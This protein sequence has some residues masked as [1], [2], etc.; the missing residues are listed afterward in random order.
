MDEAQRLEAGLQTRRDVL[1][2]E[3]VDRALANA[4]EFTRPFQEFVSGNA[5][6]NAADR[7]H[8]RRLSGARGHDA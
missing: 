3:Y 7:H 8:H 4:D 2:A 5:R 6:Q 1:G